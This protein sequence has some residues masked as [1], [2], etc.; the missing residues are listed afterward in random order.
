VDAL[1]EP[2]S[3]NTLLFEDKSF[4]VARLPAVVLN[5][6]GG[7][8]GQAMEITQ[9]EVEKVAKLARLE[10]TDIEKAAFAKQLSQILTHVETL[11]QYDTTGV[12]PTATVLGQVN[13]FRPDIA[14]PSLS[15]ERAVAN[16]PESAD[17]FFVVPKIIE[18]RQPL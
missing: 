2:G 5:F 17:G 13:V 4:S 18:D 6:P 9:Q 12:E 3:V 11:K 1:D 7:E 14:R 15:V 16:A 8:Q 10:L